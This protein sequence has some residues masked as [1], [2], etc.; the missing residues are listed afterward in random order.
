MVRGRGGGQTGGTTRPTTTAAGT[1]TGTGGL[2]TGE[3][4]ATTRWPSL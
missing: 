3:I 4:I 1:G 2:I